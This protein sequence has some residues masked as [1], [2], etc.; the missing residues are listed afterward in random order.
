MRPRGR[1]C[2]LGGL[3]SGWSVERVTRAVR[4]SR[5]GRRPIGAPARRGCTVISTAARS[6][7]RRTGPGLAVHRGVAEPPTPGARARW[8][9]RVIQPYRPRPPRSGD[10]AV[11]GGV[12]AN[13]PWPWSTQDL[14]H[15]ARTPNR[16]RSVRPRAGSLRRRPVRPGGQLGKRHPPTV[17]HRRRFRPSVVGATPMGTKRWPSSST[18]SL[19]KPTP[20]RTLLAHVDCQ[21]PTLAITA[22]RVGQLALRF[23][24]LGSRHSSLRP[25]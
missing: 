23:F 11:S 20:E 4:G 25:V 16:S 7:T 3:A 9:V 21:K 18:A 2:T 14:C 24:A 22:D 8:G 12:L 5:G 13:V 1:C 17:G 10:A 19:E 6:T 15:P